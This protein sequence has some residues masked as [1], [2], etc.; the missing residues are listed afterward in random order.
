M[1]SV[2]R[3]YSKESSRTPPLSS[4]PIILLTLR[5]SLFTA[6][7]MFQNKKNSKLTLEKFKVDFKDI[8]WHLSLEDQQKFQIFIVRYGNIDSQ[9]RA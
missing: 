9:M 8:V 7:P 4:P 5:L 3:L 6:I 2:H 1:V